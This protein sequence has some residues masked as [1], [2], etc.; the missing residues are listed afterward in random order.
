MMVK[1][2]LSS[3]KRVPI[4]MHFPDRLEEFRKLVI[5][6]RLSSATVIGST[7]D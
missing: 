1:A 3:L 7:G 5:L 2:L 4:D 6:Q